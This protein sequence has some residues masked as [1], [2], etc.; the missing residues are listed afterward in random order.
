MK[1]NRKELP[2]KNGVKFRKMWVILLITAAVFSV[3]LQAHAAVKLN[4]IKLT[5]VKGQTE[6][7]KVKGTSRSV[8]WSSGKKSVATVSSKGK[9]T[10]KKAGTAVI[11]AKVGSKTYSCKVTVKAKLDLANYRNKTVKATANAIG[12]IAARKDASYI[13]SFRPFATSGSKRNAYDNN[14]I[15]IFK[16]DGS[17]TTIQFVENSYNKNLYVHGVKLLGQSRSSVTKKLKAK[18]FTAGGA[19]NLYSSIPGCSELQYFFKGREQISLYYT[20]GGKIKRF[21]YYPWGSNGTN[22]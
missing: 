2:M 9:V 6:T 22:G 11:K 12:G 10:A 13:W 17:G 21:R 4:K 19:M 3:H 20:S 16:S 1:G 18:G 15:L 8:K 5:L 7:L 14:N